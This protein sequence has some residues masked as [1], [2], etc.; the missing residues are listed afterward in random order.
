MLTREFTHLMLRPEDL[1]PV[2]EYTQVVGT[3]NP[4]VA[5]VDGRVALLVRVVEQPT[6]LR[7]GF[8][9]S[10][11]F[12]DSGEFALDWFEADMM[13]RSDP[14]KYVSLETGTTR[15]RFFSY[16]QVFWSSDGKTIDGQG[17]RLMPQGVYEEYGIEDPRI[18]KI[19]G[20]YYI[21]YV[22]VS[23]HGVSTCLMSTTDF[24][25]FQRHGII[26][27]PENKDV[28]LFPEK[29][30]GDYVAMHRPVPHMQFH[31]PEI[32]I[33]RSPDLLHWGMHQQLLGAN[34]EWGNNRIGGGTPPIK[35]REGWLTFYHGSQ[36][37]DGDAAVGTYTAGLLLLDAQQPRNLIGWSTQPV[38]RPELD[39]EMG[40]YVANVVFPTGIVE[41]GDL[42]YV[43]YGAADTKAAVVG[44]RRSDV[45]GALVR[46]T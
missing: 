34:A 3:F 25:T 12:S 43:Y 46:R 27:C 39:F 29:I 23:R 38:M 16:L 35:T 41:R 40:G 17:P 2:S 19:G 37:S 7:D 21:T 33:A 31:P 14:R 22:A 30:F 44:Y 28:V 45:M 36:K 6:E 32:W 10:P 15:L 5:D 4:G 18:T 8:V 11:G 1:S 24:Q 42:L 9:A 13:D 26:F 20:T